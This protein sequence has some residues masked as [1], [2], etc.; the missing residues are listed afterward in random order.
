L[1][2]AGESALL[3]REWFMGKSS[4]RSFLGFAWMRRNVRGKRPKRTRINSHSEPIL[5]VAARMMM[6]NSMMN[7]T[8]LR[9]N[10]S[11]RPGKMLHRL[12]GRARKIASGGHSVPSRLQSPASRGSFGRDGTWLRFIEC[13]DAS[14]PSLPRRTHL[15]EAAPV[16]CGLVRVGSEFWRRIM[17]RLLFEQRSQSFC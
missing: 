7:S 1:R 13:N 8:G 6:T 9:R 12:A 4:T 14:V 17:R 16:R 2:W 3:T 10:Y 15:A 5:T 11:L